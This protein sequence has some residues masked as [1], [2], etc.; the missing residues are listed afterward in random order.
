MEA[1]LAGVDF[2]DAAAQLVESVPGRAWKDEWGPS[3]YRGLASAV[4]TGLAACP[5]PAA[6][7]AAPILSHS[8]SIGDLVHPRWLYAM[9]RA[10]TDVTCDPSESSASGGAGSGAVAWSGVTKLR[11]CFPHN[12]TALSSSLQMALVNRGMNPK[13][14]GR[15]PA[16]V[17]ARLFHDAPPC[18]MVGLSRGGEPSWLREE[19]RAFSADSLEFDAEGRWRPPLAHAKVIYR[20]VSAV[21]GVATA[22]GGDERSSSSA[23]AAA[24]GGGGA[25]TAA[26][27]YV[28]SHNLSRAAWGQNRNQPHNVELGVFLTTPSLTRAA[29]WRTRL[30]MV[31]PINE[32]SGKSKY[33][34]LTPTNKMYAYGGLYWI[35]CA[36]ITTQEA[37]DAWMVKWESQLHEQVRKIRPDVEKAAAA[38]EALLADFDAY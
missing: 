28:G 27:A 38:I 1:L 16:E 22:M 13:T 23:G 34:A 11:V 14:F 32:Y 29:V 30:P 7:T 37:Q 8:G 31:P 21:A 5:W 10:L 26:W 35:G 33:G 2:S 17:R 4:R 3:G 36:K 19:H 9:E 20:A 6:E 15:V 18:A 12:S 24:T 25:T